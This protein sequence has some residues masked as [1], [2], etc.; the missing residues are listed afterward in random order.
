MGQGHIPPEYP[1]VQAFIEHFCQLRHYPFCAKK[2]GKSD[3]KI[4]KKLRLPVNVLE[5]INFLPDQVPND[6]GHYKYKI[7]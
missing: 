6:Y 4:C 3:F 5:E 1:K 2:G 7:K